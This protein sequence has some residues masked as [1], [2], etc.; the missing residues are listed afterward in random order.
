MM[1]FFLIF[2]AIIL[3]IVISC[4]ILILI[5]IHYLKKYAASLGY[6]SMSEIREMIKKG[7][8]EAKYRPKSITGMT[9]ILVPRIKNDYKGFNETTFFNKVETS[10]IAIL[11][12]ISNES[13]SNTDEL[14]LIKDEIEE[15]IINNKENEI[16]EK[17]SDIKFHQHTIKKY[18]NEGGALTITVASSLEYYYTLKIKDKIKK[19]F[20]EYKKQTSYTT[21]YVH[22]YDPNKYEKSKTYLAAHCPNCGAILTNF[23][24]NYC[25][26]CNSGVEPINLKSWFISECKEDKR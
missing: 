1:K 4:G 8:D 10:I 19:E 13:L 5:I 22:I 7:D 3:G 2:L 18:S 16:K 14:N 12:S 11:N 24:D 23:N 6:S 15:I 25:E 9:N 17:F 26:F 20:K 21:K